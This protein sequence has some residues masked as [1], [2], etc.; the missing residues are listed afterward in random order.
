MDESLVLALRTV[1]GADLGRLSAR[2]GRD[3]GVEYRIAICELARAGL[4][5]KRGS[6]I[7]LTEKGMALANEVAVRVM[8]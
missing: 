6:R 8:A 2:Y 3:A 1:E 4:A 7:S 5:V